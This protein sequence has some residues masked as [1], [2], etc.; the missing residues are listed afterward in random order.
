M[1]N[2]SLARKMLVLTLI[3]AA[4]TLLVAYVAWNRMAVVNDQVQ[5]LVGRTIAKRELLNDFYINFLASIRAQKNSILSVEDEAAKS[6]ASLSRNAMADA[7]ASLD[8]LK[9]L[10]GEDRVEGQATAAEGLVKAYENFQKLNGEALD[11]SVQNSNVKAR[12]IL[13][14]DV[15]RQVKILSEYFQRW[16][17]EATAK[18]ETTP[19][20][21]ERL[22][23]LYSVN[24]SL[25]QFYPETL[26]HIDSSSREQM[27]A[28]ERKV[29]DL[30]TS[31]QNALPTVSGA[32]L[33]SLVAPNA[34]LSDLKSAYANLF[35]LSRLDTTNRSTALSLNETKVAGDETVARIKAVDKLLGQEGTIGQDRSIATYTSALWWI[36]AATIAG[37]AL[38][39]LLA[40]LITRSITRPIS[41]VCRLSQSMADGDLRER[42]HLDSEDEVGLLSEATNSLA[43]SLGKIV[44]QIQTVSESL[45]S[46]AGDLSGVS[47]H[48]ISQSA[49]ASSKA[50]S[51]A[52]ASE[53]LSSNISTMA[54]AAE[55]M[56]V[57][58]ASISSASEEMSINVGTISSAAEQTSTNVSVVSGAVEEISSSFADVLRDVRE[59]SNVAGDAS[60]MADSATETIQLL[61]RSGAEISKVTETIK[62]I[63][64]QTNLLALNA[65][66]EATSAGEAGKGFAVVAHEIKELANQSAKAAEDIARKIEGVQNNTRQAVDVIQNVSQIIKEI[67]A[68]AGRISISVEKQTRAAG[69]ISQNVSEANKGVGDIARSIAEV[70]KAATDMSRNVS[71]AAHGATNV[72]RNVAEAA[73]A[74]G[75]I[76]SDIHGVSEASRSTNE[77]ASRVSQSAEQLAQIG[78]ELRH[79]VSRFRTNTD[80]SVKS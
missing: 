1:K 34:A 63:A 61:N 37:L 13:D 57:N 30:Q 42:I 21:V 33:T 73:K 60:R 44:A 75:G 10:I 48:L 77:S 16:L 55:E 19:G 79:L 27:D 32:N 69:M 15:A 14:N 45:A 38:G 72:S 56:S 7:K 23:A 70:A 4:T 9:E 18:G 40:S 35:R 62:M 41:E 5:H 36:G 20:Q 25:L 64:L 3:L 17:D 11:L 51:V 52:S 76:S 31:I 43:D 24:S 53:Q 39:G 78:K 68:S 8:Q 66:I 28:Q 26:N 80:I 2:L 58:V 6:F 22:K 46:S 49:V 74:A 71:E 12:R 59:G 65:T 50:T 47:T 29:A 54:A 67:N